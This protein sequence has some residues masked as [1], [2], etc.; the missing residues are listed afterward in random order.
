MSP[1]TPVFPHIPKNSDNKLLIILFIYSPQATLLICPAIPNSN[2][3][4]QTTDKPN[5]NFLEKAEKLR[6]VLG[7]FPFFFFLGYNTKIYDMNIV[8]ATCWERNWITNCYCACKT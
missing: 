3:D 7:D 4:H 1:L 2:Q 8:S 5:R 6:K